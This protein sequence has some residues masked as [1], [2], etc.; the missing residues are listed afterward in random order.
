MTRA[1]KRLTEPH[2]VYL[3]ELLTETDTL[4]MPALPTGFYE[5]KHVYENHRRP[6]FFKRSAKCVNGIDGLALAG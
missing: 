1:P 5:V 4:G 6:P 3:C 2:S